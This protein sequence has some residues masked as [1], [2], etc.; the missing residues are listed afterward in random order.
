MNVGIVEVQIRSSNFFGLLLVPPIA[1]I[2][3]LMRG[4][5]HNHRRWRALGC[6][7]RLDEMVG[8]VV[9]SYHQERLLFD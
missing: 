8:L 5:M 1:S 7:I 2:W 3:C 9:C 4:E 6:V